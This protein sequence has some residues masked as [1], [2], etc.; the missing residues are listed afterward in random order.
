MS[1]FPS[2]HSLYGR[3]VGA[4][5]DGYVTGQNGFKEIVTALTSASTG[6]NI[7]PSGVTTLSV[8]TGSSASGSGAGFIMDAPVKGVRKTLANVTTSSTQAIT[9]VTTAG[10]FFTGTFAA[11]AVTAGSSYNTITMNGGGEA[12]DLVGLSSSYYMVTSLNGFSTADA[13]FSVT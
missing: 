6:T 13:I 5:Y 4:T 10:T 2:M 3:I 11:G 1:D 12:V 7:T 8:S 9:I